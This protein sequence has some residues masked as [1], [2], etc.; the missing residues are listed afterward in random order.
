M[1]AVVPERCAVRAARENVDAGLNGLADAAVTGDDL[2][3]LGEELVWLERVGAR[4]AAESARRLEVFDRAGGAA[5]DWA[6]STAA[7][8]RHH[9]RVAPGAAWR[10]VRCARVLADQLPDTVRAFAA[11]DVS[12]SHAQ[13][14]AHAVSELPMDR[15]A[16]GEAILLP[17]ARALDPAQLAQAARRLRFTVDPDGAL[18]G[19]DAL[20]GRRHLSVASTFDGAVAVQGLLDAE[21]GATVL[22][23]LVPL[24]APT[25]P[26]DDRSPKQ[27]RADALVELARRALDGGGLPQSAG[28][29]PHI[30]ITVDAGALTGSAAPVAEMDW[31]GPI[32]A[33]TLARYL[34]DPAVARVVTAGRSEVLDVGRLT[35]MIPTGLRRALVTRDRGC[36]WPTC[37][38]PAAWCDG[39][40]LQPWHRGGSTTLTNLVLLCRVHHRFLHEGRWRLARDPAGSWRV[41]AAGDSSAPTTNGDRQLPRPDG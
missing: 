17:A 18:T 8:L 15:V 11:G 40:H 24:A 23:A 13:I 37:D 27:R 35:R 32:G 3:R 41:T 36:V 20:H 22:A 5:A 7:W 31:A 14:L 25:G 28:E 4:V 2:A 39:H 29:R 10:R 38:R 6:V 1:V 33:D 16:E 12:A 30:T 9:C 21:V 19:V 34:C 26:D